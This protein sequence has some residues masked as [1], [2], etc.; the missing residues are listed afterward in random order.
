MK[1]RISLKKPVQFIQLFHEYAPKLHYY[2]CL[3][4]IL[5]VSLNNISGFV[6]YD[7]YFGMREKMTSQAI[8]MS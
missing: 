6:K 8:C 7:L 1:Q 2:I 4:F 3:K 5:L